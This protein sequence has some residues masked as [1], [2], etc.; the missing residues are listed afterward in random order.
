MSRLGAERSRL[1]QVIG[2]GVEVVGRL[3]SNGRLFHYSPSSRVVELE[4]LA[5]A[6]FTQRSLWLSLRAVVDDYPELDVRQLDRL[7]AG[8]TE[9]YER[10]LIEHDRAAAV[11]FGT[12][13][14]RVLQ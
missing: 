3:K 5:S 12:T 2:L 10:L 14:G 4:M 6:V 8:A 11:A 9:M 7:I 13:A 1:K